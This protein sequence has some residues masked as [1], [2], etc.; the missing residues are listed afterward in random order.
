MSLSMY[1]TQNTVA[2]TAAG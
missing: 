2:W 1:V